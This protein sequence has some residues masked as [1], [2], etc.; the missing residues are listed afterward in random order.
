MISHLGSRSRRLHVEPLEDRRLLAVA[1]VDTHLDVV[2]IADGMTSLREAIASTNLAVGNDTIEFDP[3]LDGAIINLV[4]PLG[5][6]AISDSVTI[7]ASNLAAGLTIDA[8]HGSDSVPGT[9]DGFR[10][11]NVDD[12]TNNDINVS[13]EALTIVG[14]DLDFDSGGGIFNEENL[15]I[16][17][18]LITGNAAYSGGGI[19]TIATLEMSGSTLSGNLASFGGGIHN[20]SGTLTINASTLSGKL[21]K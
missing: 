18:S 14:G 20:R 11:F 21:S 4:Q 12:G 17:D 5:E 19:Y 15:T 6:L 3:S 9:G 10:I 1:T 8:G 16:V 2:D 7:D 13:L